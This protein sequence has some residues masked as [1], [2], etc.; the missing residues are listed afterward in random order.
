MQ[1]NKHLTSQE[2]INNLSDDL[3]KDIIIL[4]ILS[5]GSNCDV[6]KGYSSQLDKIIILKIF[7][8]NEYYEREYLFITNIYH[9]GIISM[10]LELNNDNT[11][12]NKII[13]LEYGV[14]GDLYNFLDKFKNGIINDLQSN[15]NFHAEIF[16]LSIFKEI[17]SIID[18]IHNKKWCHL[19]LKCDNII[20]DDKYNIKIIDFDHSCNIENLKNHLRFIHY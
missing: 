2:I 1:S 6:I 18:I 13:P 7:K 9:S 14:H 19:D 20:F 5:N 10:I 17:L 11:K 12:K 8:I 3:K 4:E 15:E 16:I